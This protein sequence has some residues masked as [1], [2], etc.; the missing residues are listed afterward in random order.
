MK[1]LTVT[2][3]VALLAIGSAAIASPPSSPVQLVP[4]GWQALEGCRI[5]MRRSGDL[6][7]PPAPKGPA[8]FAAIGTVVPDDASP[9]PIMTSDYM[10]PWGRAPIQDVGPGKPPRLNHYRT[11][12]YEVPLSGSHLVLRTPQTPQGV[13]VKAHGVPAENGGTRITILSAEGMD[14]GQ[15]VPTY[16]VHHICPEKGKPD[17]VKAGDLV[18]GSIWSENELQFG[19]YG[20]FGSCW[21]VEDDGCDPVMPKG[22]VLMHQTYVEGYDPPPAG[23]QVVQSRSM[24]ID[25]DGVAGEMMALKAETRRDQALAEEAKAEAAEAKK[26][27]AKARMCPAMHDSAHAAEI[28]MLLQYGGAGTKAPY[29]LDD[30]HETARIVSVTGT[31]T[32]RTYFAV[33]ASRTTVW[34]FSTM[35]PAMIAGVYAVGDSPQGVSGVMADTPVVL[36]EGMARDMVEVD[37][38]PKISF[39]DVGRRST[40]MNAAI[41]KTGLGRLPTRAF[42]GRHI[43]S[44]DIDTGTMAAKAKIPEAGTIRSTRPIVSTGLLPG[45]DGIRQMIEDGSLVRLNA[46]TWQDLSARKLIEFIPTRDGYGNAD[47]EQSL[48]MPLFATR[49]ITRLPRHARVHVVVPAGMTIPAK[50][51]DGSLLFRYLGKDSP[52]EDPSKIDRQEYRDREPEDHAG[53][54]IQKTTWNED[55]T[56]ENGPLHRNDQ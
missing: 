44:F 48:S 27:A 35:D 32:V 2:A 19:A 51:T 38:C 15:A 4:R 30:A 6:Q 7:T 52:W 54:P 5:E 43:Q 29:V 11:S 20:T 10:G 42:T 41:L 26:R 17:Y 23:S 50:A 39:E 45:D 22:A 55:G 21:Q 33:S 46:T 31:P 16:Q 40:D 49:T 24:W 12:R 18:I 8:A 14:F 25:L 28:V 53:A 56:I 13:A 47:M 34:D 3:T 36:R 9:V 37:D 1:H